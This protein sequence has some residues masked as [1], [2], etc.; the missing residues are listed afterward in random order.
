LSFFPTD[1][2]PNKPF[3]VEK[4]LGLTAVVDQRRRLLPSRQAQRRALIKCAGFEC[5]ALG[6]LRDPASPQ[7]STES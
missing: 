2:E 1:G 4:L 6:C 7:G 3:F 5:G